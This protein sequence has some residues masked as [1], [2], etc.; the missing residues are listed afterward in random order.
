MKILLQ[1]PEG[2]KSKALKYQHEL[3]GEGH[4]VY[5]SASPCYGACDLPISDAK[6]LNIDKIIHYGHAP[7]RNSVQDIEI[8]YKEYHYDVNMNV[9][10]QSLNNLKDY[11]II[12]LVT[13][14]QH[15][16]QYEQF[17]QYYIDNGKQII[18]GD[19]KYKSV[20]PGQVLGCDINAALQN[21]DEV[22]CVVIVGAGRFHYLALPSENKPVLVINPYTH[23]IKFVEDEIKKHQ[24]KIQGQVVMATEGKTF[25]I[26]V[27]TKSGQYDLQL[28]E[29]L[30]NKLI[31]H[32]KQAVIL[33]A[34]EFTPENLTNFNSFDA[35]LN[36]ACPRL[37]ED[38]QELGKP[39][40]SIEHLELFW[41]LL[42]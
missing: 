15:I 26:L 42:I 8:E 40:V 28:A 22:E 23:E 13:T 20:Y 39:V 35:Y 36:T 9:I 32:N 17:K 7:L 41:Q 5:V 34:N 1:F 25:G 37:A 33:I 14:V 24:K 16:H 2:L 31:K 18:T 10:E 12:N 30:K 4:Q 27:S 6:R 11:K 19:S 38:Y 3:E 21:I 29:K